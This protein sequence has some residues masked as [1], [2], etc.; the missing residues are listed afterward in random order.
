[1]KNFPFLLRFDEVYW[2][3]NSSHL[4]SPIHSLH[5][6]HRNCV[7]HSLFIKRVLPERCIYPYLTRLEHEAKLVAKSIYPHRNRAKNYRVLHQLIK[8]PS[9][10]P[11]FHTLVSLPSPTND[12][13]YKFLERHFSAPRWQRARDAVGERSLADR[14]SVIRAEGNFD[15][16]SLS[17]RMYD[18]KY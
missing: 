3:S 16:N 4:Q 1:M 15:G 12:R 2:K 6:P 8:T 7:F 10:S 13:N 5:S 18:F 17:R 14:V 11:I 9:F